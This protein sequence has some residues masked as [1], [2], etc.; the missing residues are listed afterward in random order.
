M[1]ASDPLIRAFSQVSF[2]LYTSSRRFAMQMLGAKP[3]Y[4]L[5]PKQ[6]AFAWII[7]YY[8]RRQMPQD[9]AALAVAKFSAEKV[10]TTT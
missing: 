6:E 2:G 9:L 10:E 3:D 1:L 8:Y 7:A 5:T 4:E